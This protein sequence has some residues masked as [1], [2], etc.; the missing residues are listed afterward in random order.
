MRM[1]KNTA[2]KIENKVPG[3]TV[4]VYPWKTARN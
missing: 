1:Q 2:R 4:E 3:V